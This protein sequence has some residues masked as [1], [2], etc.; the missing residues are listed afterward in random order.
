MVR[1]RD[2][3]IV[4]LVIVAAALVGVALVLSQRFVDG[5]RKKED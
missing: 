4:F 3:A 2:R 1:V 5:N